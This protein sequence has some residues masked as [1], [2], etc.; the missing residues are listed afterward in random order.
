MVRVPGSTGGTS[1]YPH[2][3]VRR[4]V[5]SAPTS[6]SQSSAP[7]TVRTRVE[8]DRDDGDCEKCGW[9]LTPRTAD[10]LL[11]ALSVL[12]DQAYDDADEL[13]DHPVTDH[14]PGLFEVFGRLPKL[15]HTADRRW[16]RR[17]ARAFEDLAQDIEQGKWPEPSCTADE[18]ALHL[19]ID[20]APGYIDDI[21]L[22]TA[23][24]QLPTHRDDYDWSGCSDMFFQDHDV[25][26]LFHAHFDGIE[27]PD[28]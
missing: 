22:N 26:M 17:M 4:C 9:Q 6:G 1:Q 16:R 8:C 12:S 11:T 25:L 20:D 2:P 24:G 3:P 18:M 21:E 14:T 15:T 7:C 23:H 19:A 5:R 10:I 13:G 28:T 27:R